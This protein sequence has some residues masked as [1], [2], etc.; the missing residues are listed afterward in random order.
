MLNTLPT[1]EQFERMGA[2]PSLGFWPWFLLAQPAPHAE[3]LLG[4]DPDAVLDLVFATWTAD[5]AAIAPRA[6]DAPTA[7]R[8]TT[9]RRSRRC[10]ATTARA[11]TSTAQH[12]AED[13]H[14]GRRVTA[15]LLLVTGEEETQLADAP[16]IW[17]A[18]A[19][20]VTAV[21]VPGGHFVPEEAPD[22]L[23]GALAA[24]LSPRP[25]GSARA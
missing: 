3:R 2:G 25:S 5:P 12:D 14:A 24:F 4:A 13:R 10:A 23:Y 15:P 19:D 17:R 22:A 16:A 1:V 21:T 9:P 7:R 11:S 18:W 6:R 20:D 8:S